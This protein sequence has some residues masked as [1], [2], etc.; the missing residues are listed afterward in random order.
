[1][2]GPFYRNSTYNFPPNPHGSIAPRYSRAQIWYTQPRPYKSPLRYT[3]HTYIIDSD[4]SEYPNGISDCSGFVWGDMLTRAAASAYSKFV[5]K[6]GETSAWGV[7]L[8]EQKQ[9]VSMIAKRALQITRFARKLNRF[10]LP[11]AARELGLTK[12][13]R[14]ARKRGKAFGDLFLEFHFGWE[15]LVKDIGNSVNI[16]QRPYPQGKV[17]GSGSSSDS[18]YEFRDEGGG[19]FHETR[20]NWDFILKNGAL[21][22]VTNPNLFLANQMGF[23]NPLVV[24]WE[25]VPFSFVVDWFANVGQVLSSMTD[26]VGVEL[27]DTYTT[28]LERT[29]HSTHI[30]GP[31]DFQRGSNGR[32]IF[33]ERYPGNYPSTSFTIKPFK[34]FSVTRGL[35]AISLLLQQLR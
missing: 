23:V 29:T 4:R 10:D 22:K 21:V 30:W 3:S 17:S 5:G 13:P 11:G 27:T 9:S 14:G 35:T 20:R 24:A 32:A 31:D 12:I 7:N 16:L 19:Y 6:L 25:L 34:G 33:M 18:F 8:A 1:M 2:A 26:F 28:V 15:P